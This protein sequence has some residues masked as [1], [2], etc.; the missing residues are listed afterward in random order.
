MALVKALI[1]LSC[2]RCGAQVRIEADIEDLGETAD[3]PP[4]TLRNNWALRW[5]RSHAEPTGKVVR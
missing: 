3:V 2:A 4:G 5:A 1:E